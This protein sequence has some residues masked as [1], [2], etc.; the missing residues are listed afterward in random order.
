MS[1]EKGSRRIPLF[2]RKRSY[3]QCARKKG[4]NTTREANRAI[5]Q[6]KNKEN[7]KLNYYY[8]EYCGKYHLTKR[9]V[10]SKF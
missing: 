3:R 9:R 10:D 4:F 8:C 5:H 7:I 6:V 1:Q 2:D